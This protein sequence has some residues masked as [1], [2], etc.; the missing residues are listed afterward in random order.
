MSAPLTSVLYIVSQGAELYAPFIVTVGGQNP[1]LTYASFKST[2]KTDYTLPDTDPTVVK[3]DWTGNQ[4]S[5]PTTGQAALVIPP[6]TTQGMA[7]GRWWGQVRGNN[8]PYLPSVSDL[9]FFQLEITPV[10]SNRF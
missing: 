9:F 3:I 4:G 6:I 8:V 5:N 7:V 1:D 2:L 10:V